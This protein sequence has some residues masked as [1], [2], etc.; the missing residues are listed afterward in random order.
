MGNIVKQMKEAIEK[1]GSSRKDILY[2]GSDSAHRVRFLQELDDGYSFQFHNDFSANINELCHD[3]EDHE[4]C[5]L[6]KDGVRIKQ[7][8]LWSVWDYDSNSV[9][10]VNFRA[11]GVTPVPTLIEFYENYGTICDRDYKLKKVGKGMGGSFIV[12]PLDKEKFKNAKAKSYT[13]KQVKDILV[14]AY[15]PADEVT[16]NSGDEEEEVKP[17]K[18]AKASKKAKKESTLREKYEE[19]GMDE[20]K[21]ICFELGMSKKEFKAFDDEEEV[22]DE[23]F[24][25]YE[26]DDLQELL[27]NLVEDD[28]DEDE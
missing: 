20:L 6:C 18:K 8:F 12:T 26:E 23:L 3:P 15:K 10:L 17:T 13:E 22:L 19:L 28:S 9:K 21:S 25:N 4:D 1:S 14:E 2:F 27:D 24:D 11:T 16:S 7:Q 5:P